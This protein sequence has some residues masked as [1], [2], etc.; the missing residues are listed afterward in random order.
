M[1]EIAVPLIALGS[2]YVVSKQK[3]DNRSSKTFYNWKSRRYIKI[4]WFSVKQ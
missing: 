3:K 4:L 1:A 2:M